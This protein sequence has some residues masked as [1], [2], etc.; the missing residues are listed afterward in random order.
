MA[1]RKKIPEEIKKMKGTLMPCRTI[2]HM[3]PTPV[4]GMVA[5]P[6]G[7]ELDEHALQVWMRTV[8]KLSMYRV[9]TDSDLEALAIYC[10]AVSLYWKCQED[11]KSRGAVYELDTK[12]GVVNR[13]NASVDVAASQYTIIKDLQARFGLTPSDRQS[14]PTIGDGGTKDDW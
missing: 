8:D 4:T 9:L 1:G 2:P 6:F 12:Q 11:I 14:V 13:R 3:K 10:Q 5:P 7:I